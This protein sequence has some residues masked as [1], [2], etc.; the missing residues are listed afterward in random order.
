LTVDHGHA[1]EDTTESAAER[2]LRGIVEVTAHVEPFG[3]D[4]SGSTIGPE[5]HSWLERRAGRRRLKL[6]LLSRVPLLAT[7]RFC[8]GN[9]IGGK[10][11]NPL[12]HTSMA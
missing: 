7:T 11:I 5:G 9:P 2:R 6:G 4:D 3:L 1:I 10:G 12:V 8:G